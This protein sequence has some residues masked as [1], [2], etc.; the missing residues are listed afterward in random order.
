NGKQVLK[1]D[2]FVSGD[3]VDFVT[4]H[5]VRDYLSVD[6]FKNHVAGKTDYLGTI[7]GDGTWVR[8]SPTGI[9]VLGEMHET[10][11]S[12]QHVLSAVHS[13]SFITEAIASEDPAAGTE[14]KTAYD[15]HNADRYQELGIDQEKDKTKFGAEPLPPK[16]GYGMTGL[17]PYL[18]LGKGTKDTDKNVH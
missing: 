16:I 13:K 1:T 6:E 12:L 5:A 14:L 10:E 15:A 9:N 3:M 11:W 2:S 18:N 7:A 4:D 17:L 8:F